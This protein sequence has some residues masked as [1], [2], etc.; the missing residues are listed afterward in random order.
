MK[1]FTLLLGIH[2][3][4]VLL[5]P[6]LPLVWA[7]EIFGGWLSPALFLFRYAATAVL[8]LYFYTYRVDKYNL[9]VLPFSF[10]PVPFV[11]LPILGA[12]RA[13][14][15]TSIVVWNEVVSSTILFFVLTLIVSLILNHKK[16]KREGQ[17]CYRNEKTPKRIMIVGCALVG[18]LIAVTAVMIVSST[19]SEQARQER[20]STYLTYAQ[21]MTLEM[22]NG[23]TDEQLDYFNVPPDSRMWDIHLRHSPMRI[24]NDTDQRIFETTFSVSLPEIDFENYFYLVYPGHQVIPSE[25]GGWTSER[26][27]IHTVNVY[28]VNIVL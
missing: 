3:S 1:N 18:V 10:A 23:Y 20:V 13:G 17:P 9:F 16:K 27:D 7:R 8:V 6:F 24:T 5:S 4:L 19:L 28:R 11:A 15:W 26:V 21:V 12:S 2:I 14:N 25:H 22:V